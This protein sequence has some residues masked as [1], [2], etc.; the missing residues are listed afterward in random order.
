MHKVLHFLILSFVTS[1]FL[2]NSLIF[3]NN[4]IIQD[5]FGFK[6]HFSHF[7]ML[8]LDLWSWQGF[9]QQILLCFEIASGNS[10]PRRCLATIIRLNLLQWD[11]NNIKEAN[12]LL[13]YH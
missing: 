2:R 8:V 5:G 4:S 3:C 10:E 1:I 11:V 12:N 7:F 13:H 9:L 6:N